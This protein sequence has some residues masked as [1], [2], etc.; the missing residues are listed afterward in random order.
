LYI[1]QPPVS[2]DRR[3]RGRALI[4]FGPLLAG[5]TVIVLLAM[6]AGLYGWRPD[7]MRLIAEVLGGVV[8][9]LAV[10]LF[11]R[12]AR[13][14]RFSD[15][16]LHNIEARVSGI[17]ESAMDA[18][19]TVDEHQ[20]VVLFNA[21][22]EKVFRRPRAAVLG[23]KLDILIPERL[24]HAHHKHIDRFGATGVTSRR[25]GVATVLVGLRAN[26]EEFPIEA[27]ISQHIENGRKLFTV[28]LRDVTER[29]R[30]EE[31]L[32][33]NEA[34]LRGI[35]DSAM[36]AIIT[37]DESEDIVLFNKAAEEVFGRPRSE[38]LGAPLSQFIPERFRGTHS[39]HIERF[40]EAS[41][42]SRRMGAQRIVTGLRHNGEE[43]PIDASISYINE[44]GGKFYTVILRD[45]TERV[46]ADEALRKSKEELREL[47]SV[48][49]SIR[50]QEKSRIARELHDELAQAL[51]ALKMDLNWVKD[52]L[53]LHE[54]Q[55]VSKL[56]AMQI[57]VDGTVKATRRIAADLRPL[58]LDDLGLIPA[59][60][61]LVKN[62]TQRT[63]IPCDFSADPPELELQDPHATAIF[64]IL[65]ESLAN[66]AKHARASAVDVTV[67]MG[68][69]EIT[70]R[71]RDNGCGF[72]PGHSRKPNSFGLVG[73]R[74][75]AYLLDGEVA[76]DSAPG[77]GTVIEVH[78]PLSRTTA[79]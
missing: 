73:L 6:A 26:N 46:R 75:R 74:E 47:A 3:C 53:P 67:D 5:G 38:A 36:D 56:E 42:V 10:A 43:F 49:S 45:V 19:V 79:P 17:V 68:D 44:R 29:S 78:I 22:A 40:G 20:T 21:A 23:Q 64:R 18:I 2:L 13:Q 41:V 28:I 25:M 57:M 50:E 11:Y 37:V 76:V 35:L 60:E 65:Q 33:R 58:M 66:I 32:S 30:A 4:I 54:H 55:I 51:T 71:V 1:H 34:R 9:L 61:W 77:K 63:G 52:T 16:S 59:A 62:F 24:R 69:G 15:Q 31:M 27:S 14:R 8:M 7:E 48:G 72:D 70:L 12:Q 39:A